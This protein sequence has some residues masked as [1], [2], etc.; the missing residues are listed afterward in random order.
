[1]TS[2]HVQQQ[3]QQQQQQHPPLAPDNTAAS[4][5]RQTRTRTLLGDQNQRYN[6]RFLLSVHFVTLKPIAEQVPSS[7]HALTVL[8]WIRTGVGTERSESGQ[9]FCDAIGR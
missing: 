1:M 3:Q 4:S 7:D 6:L 2:H 5:R 9:Q 8:S